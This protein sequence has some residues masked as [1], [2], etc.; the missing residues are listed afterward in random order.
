MEYFGAFKLGFVDFERSHQQNISH[1]L[2][3]FAG[4]SLHRQLEDL[5]RLPDWT[6]TKAIG[7]HQLRLPRAISIHDPDFSSIGKAV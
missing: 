1:T 5:S 6:I 3:R 4:V 7:I 2:F